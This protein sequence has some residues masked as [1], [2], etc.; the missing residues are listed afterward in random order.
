MS[1]DD[2]GEGAEARRAELGRR[3]RTYRQRRKSP[4]PGY[5][6]VIGS[7]VAL[8]VY[9]GEGDLGL[10]YRLWAVL[11]PLGLALGSA[12]NRFAP[13]PVVPD[14][15]GRLRLDLHEHGV[16]VRPSNGGP[17]V[18]RP[19]VLTAGKGV[20]IHWNAPNLRLVWNDEAHGGEK[21]HTRLDEFGDSDSLRRALVDG[22]PPKTRVPAGTLLLWAVAL[23]LV[24]LYVW[25]FVP[26]PVAIPENADHLERFCSDEDMVFEESPR[27]DGAGGHGIVDW[28]H[29]DGDMYESTDEDPDEAE[30]ASPDDM[31]DAALIACGEARLGDQIDVCE[32]SDIFA[33][34]DHGDSIIDAYAVVYDFT[35]YEAA[36][37]ERV[38]EVAVGPDPYD[39]HCPMFLEGVVARILSEPDPD[40]VYAALAPFTERDA[41]E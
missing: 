20:P 22:L 31:A 33:R 39:S 8:V 21:V 25:M 30:P 38:G 17:S 5:G 34:G 36:T 11:A 4:W 9:F 16:V 7:L 26:L 1:E 13:A 19:V 41:A 23:A 10:S 37:H 2:G 35:V 32:Y 28:V 15:R 18:V 27:F 6:A 29:R 12:Y 3:L 40:D 14:V 24:P